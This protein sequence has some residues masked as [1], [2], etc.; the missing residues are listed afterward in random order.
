MPARGGNVATNDAIVDDIDN[1]DAEQ[2]APKRKRA[3]RAKKEVVEKESD[4]NTKLAKRG[5]PAKDAAKPKAGRAKKT[6]PEE[7][8]E[9]ET[10]SK[11][12][13]GLPRGAKK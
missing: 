8:A 5:R 9:E 4:E 1:E 11:P 12:K 2:P 7:V 13:R 10:V 6:A 3:T